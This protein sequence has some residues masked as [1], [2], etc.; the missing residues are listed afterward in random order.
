M[1]RGKMRNHT[2]DNIKINFEEGFKLN[3]DNPIFILV[4]KNMMLSKEADKLDGVLGGVIKLALDQKSFFNGELKTKYVI[5]TKIGS[6]INHIILIG[7]GNVDEIKSFEIEDL[8]S[9]IFNIA[10]ELKITNISILVSDNLGKINSQA[11][12][13]LLASGLYRSSYKF[14]KYQTETIESD[15]VNMLTANIHLDNKVDASKEY[16][17]FYKA[18]NQGIFLAKDC[19]NEPSNELYPESYVDVIKA[20]IKDYKNISLEVLGES[21]M[22]KLGMNSLIC[23]GQGSSKES[24][25]VVLKYNGAGDNSKYISLV[26]KGVTFDTGGISIKPSLNMDQMK[27]DMTGSACVLGAIST[28]A[29]RGAKINVVG[30]LA[31]V[32]NMPDGNA[33]RPG[34]IVRSMSGKTIEI[35]NT[36]AEG[37]LI[38]ADAL[39]YVQ[40]NFDPEIIIDLATL[41]GA[42]SV[43]LGSVYAG[44]FSNNDD[45]ALKL[46][47]S[48]T[49]VNE[50]LWRMPLGKEYHEMIK[51]DCADIANISSGGGAGSSTAA[52]F[53]EKFIDKNRPWVHLDIASVA[54]NK[55]GQNGAMCSG[56][57]GF[58]IKL[59][60][61]F[62]YDN[63]EKK[64]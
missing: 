25:L 1:D 8:G 19:V 37:R 26:G 9:L 15:K 63:Y 30:I 55:K 28:L 58:G 64:S 61:Q 48:G 3:Q 6:K 20:E 59:L 52:A 35:L 46:I 42:I 17:E 44:C 14:D 4:D 18:I 39:T 23:V 2:V 56:A 5:T 53:L 36:D 7:L 12:S 54:W 13:A 16:E 11:G 33:Q 21:D 27:Y 32:E 47:N 34:D 31:L 22:K 10:H 62:I 43:A 29:K 50:R 41:T 49:K 24:K 45:L 60:N 57:S 51:S 38:L 40:K